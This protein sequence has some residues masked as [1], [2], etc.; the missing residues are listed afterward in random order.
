MNIF[1]HILRQQPEI[2]HIECSH[3]IYL[4]TI[5]ES[6]NFMYRLY[7]SYGFINITNVLQITGF[8]IILI[9]RTYHKNVNNHVNDLEYT[10]YVSP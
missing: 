7:F 4:Q 6:T 8:L 2:V 1:C 9:C 5:R 10:N 3:I